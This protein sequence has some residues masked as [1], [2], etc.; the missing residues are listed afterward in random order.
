LVVEEIKLST[1]K[2]AR[3][4]L[5]EEFGDVLLFESLLET[6]SVFIVPANLT[7]FMQPN[8]QQPF[9]WK[10]RTMQA[11]LLGAQI[12][13]GLLLTFAKLFKEQKTR[14]HSLHALQISLRAQ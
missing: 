1:K 7:H 2:H 8:A 11:S 5:Q 13:T 9:L 4:N 14:C 12:Y 6:T 3:Q 10:N